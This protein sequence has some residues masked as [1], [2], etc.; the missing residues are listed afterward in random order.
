MK[1]YI[2][3][4]GPGAGKTSII[5]KLKRMGENVV[6]E[7]AEDVI[8]EDLSWG[9]EKPWE[10]SDFSDRILQLQEKRHELALQMEAEVVF[11]DRSPI[12]TIAYPM[13]QKKPV[14]AALKEAMKKTIEDS[15]YQKTVFLIE[16]A[17]FCKP[18]E[19]RHE[20]HGEA[21]RIEKY[22]EKLYQDAGFEIIKIP[23]GR[24]E[25]RARLILKHV[26]PDENAERKTKS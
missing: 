15:C 2:L 22:L 23:A 25:V 11:F 1:W 3:T 16:N 20:T 5:K 24:L 7:A 17:G 6:F 9:V 12:D 18:T 4:G 19:I 13:M 26:Y 14:S 10:Q 21:V 8:T